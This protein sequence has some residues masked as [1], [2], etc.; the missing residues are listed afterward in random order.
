MAY[1]MDPQHSLL[2]FR[3]SG[4]A[5]GLPIHCVEK[6]IHA[7]E[8]VPL[9]EPAAPVVGVFSMAGKTIPVL[10]MRKLFG[11][12]DREVE[13][14]DPY[15][16]LSWKN[17]V[18]AMIVDAVS[19]VEEIGEPDLISSKD[20]MA[21]SDFL[22]ATALTSEGLVLIPDCEKILSACNT[23]KGQEA[24]WKKAA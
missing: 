14:Y 1:I 6:V 20:I 4:Y 23:L 7:V 5:Y 15:L 9:P 12:P 16:I 10:N 13:L 21:P 17:H 3:L 19:G 8:I 2:L 18:L 11:F 24:T 22:L